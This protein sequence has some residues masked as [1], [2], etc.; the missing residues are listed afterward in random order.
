MDHRGIYID[1]YTDKL[2][3]DAHNRL[4]AAKF[5]KLQSKYTE[6]R[7]IYITAAHVHGQTHNLFGRL[8][9]LLQSKTQDD[10]LIET[11]DTL[12][13]E[14]CAIGE[15]C[16]TKTRAAWWTREINRLRIRRRILQ[17]MRSAFMNQKNFDAQI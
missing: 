14:C 16:S 8:R 6:C 11:L 9:D 1:F 4:P 12:L 2:F 15:Q 5:R 13:G 3:G 10:A 7:K 17:K